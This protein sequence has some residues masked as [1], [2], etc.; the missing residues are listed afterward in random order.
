MDNARKKELAR[1]YKERKQVFG[2]FAVR[3]EAAGKIWV[4]ASRNLDR[5]QTRTF[6][7]LRNDGH[8]NK[9]MQALWRNHG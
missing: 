9:T 5:E 4:A 1:E 3:C 2:I 7:Q 6:F 8:P